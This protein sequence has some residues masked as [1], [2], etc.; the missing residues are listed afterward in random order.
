MSGMPKVTAAAE[1]KN[2]EITQI[3]KGLK[4]VPMCEEYEKMISGML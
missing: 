3:A 2:P 1:Q 4:D